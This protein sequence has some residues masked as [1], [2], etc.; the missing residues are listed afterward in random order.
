[1]NA[2]LIEAVGYLAAAASVF[3]YVSN[4]MIPLRIAA[5][6]ASALFASYFFLKG[7]YPLFALNAFLVP[8]NIWRLRQMQHLIDDVRA[9]TSGD[10]DYEWLRPYMKPAKLTK[11]FTLHR[12]GDLSEEAYVLVRG[13]VSLLELGV[14]L[15]P[16]ALFGEMGLFTDENR[17]TAT[18]VAATDVELLCVRYDDLLQLSAQNPQFGFYLMRLMVRRMQ[19]NVELAR[20]GSKETEERGM[21]P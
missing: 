18:A 15:K 2:I 6:L 7:L 5:I 8:V 4:T 10:F 17:R 19:H 3:V 12:L 1:M 9:A 14:T 11:G 13:N 21:A 16:G 20:T